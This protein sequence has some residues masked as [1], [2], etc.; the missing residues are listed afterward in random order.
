[1]YHKDWI[2]V[3]HNVLTSSEGILSI[4]GHGVCL[5]EDDNLDARAEDGACAG[6]AEDLTTDYPNTAVIRCVQLR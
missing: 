2:G 6:K 1:M 5:V 4:V 3:C